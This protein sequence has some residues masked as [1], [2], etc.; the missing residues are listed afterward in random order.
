M[1]LNPEAMLYLIFS[2]GSALFV[3]VKIST[4][5]YAGILFL[6][7]NNST[8][9]SAFTSSPYL[10]FVVAVILYQPD[11]NVE[12]DNGNTLFVLSIFSNT[13]SPDS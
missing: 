12:I 10:S 11:F 5:L 7:L 6:L 3:S 4:A 8:Y 2:P 1:F 9:F 13:F